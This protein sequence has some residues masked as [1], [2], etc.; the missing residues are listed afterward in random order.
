MMYRKLLVVLAACTAGSQTYAQ[1][2][3]RYRAEQVP[4]VARSCAIFPGDATDLNNSGAVIGQRCIGEG[5][6][7]FI[8]HNGEIR[9]LPQDTEGN[10]Q[11]LKLNDRFDAIMQV[12]SATGERRH[13]FVRD[14]GATVQINPLPGD[15]DLS[16]SSLNN[17]RQVLGHSVGSAVG[18]PFIWH[19][20]RARALS[21]LPDT[22]GLTASNLNDFGIAIGTSSSSQDNRFMD[23]R[24]VL[25]VFDTVMPL[26]LPRNAIGSTGRDI[27]NLGQA[28][29]NAHFDDSG[30]EPRPRTQVYL[31]HL[32]RLTALPLL[33]IGPDDLGLVA[34]AGDINN[35]GHVVGITVHREPF[36]ETPVRRAT[37]WRD[38]VVYDLQDLLVDEDG[39]PVT[40]LRL[41]SALA[42]NDVG[43]I[44]VQEFIDPLEPPDYFVLTPVRAAD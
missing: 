7:A 9:L 28:V 16:L 34:G 35:H 13:L 38:G 20:G 36:N 39:E 10:A 17:R 18:L 12:T 29:F 33:P 41:K 3:S 40:D 2:A 22:V 4:T 37:L 23:Q 6:F 19:R 5:N 1:T 26:P 11:S 31:W 15:F 25:W 24:A 30:T 8:A 14:D 32:G 42:I 44:L 43:Q 21:A 27:N